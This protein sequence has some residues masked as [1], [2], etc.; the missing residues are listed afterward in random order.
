MTLETLLNE[1]NPH[2]RAAATFA[3]KH[4]LVLAGAGTGK[5]KTIVARAAHLITQ[6]TP[7]HRIHILT[8]TRR[9]AS[10]IV[11][12]VKLHLGE[13]AAGLRA[14]TFHTFCMSLIRQA[15][16]LFGVKGYSVIDRDDQIQLF[17]MIRGGVI[18]KG[19]RFATAAEICNIY[20]YAR[21]TGK[22]LSDTLVEQYPEFLASKEKFAEIMSAYQARKHTRKYLDYDDILDVVVQAM[23]QSEDTAQWIAGH[24]DHLLVDEMQDTNPLQWQILAPLKSLCVLF[25]VGDDAQSIYKFRGADFN[26]IHSFSERVPSSTIFKLTENYR[27][28][29]EILDVSNWLLDQSPLKYNKRLEAVRGS[30]VLPQLHNF[31]NEWEEAGWIT[32]DILQRR[33]EVGDKWNEHM[34]LT[35]SAFGARAMESALLAA[36]IPY[37]YVGGTKLLE[38]AHVRDMLSLVRI[39][40]NPSDELAIIRYLTLFHGVGE[41]TANHAVEAMLAAESLS[42]A[43]VVLKDQKKIPLDAAK[44]IEAVAKSLNNVAGAIREAG[45]TLEKVFETKYQNQDWPKRR[46]DFTMVEK[47]AEKHTSILSFIEEY[48]LDPVHTTQIDHDSTQDVVTL[49]TIHSA[50]GTECKTCYLLN[51]GPGAFPSRLDLGSAD[52]VEES[53]RTLYVALTRAKDNLLVTRRTLNQWAT[54][55]VSDPDIEG[56]FFNTLPDGLFELILHGQKEVDPLGAGVSKVTGYKFVGGINLS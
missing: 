44:G 37:V 9:A 31:R 47:L 7:A 22:S 8:F 1:L 55:E 23:K 40:G 15:P 13:Q 4:A 27:S 16:N 18:K 32:G 14:S 3:S 6:G 34:I 21:N 50:K 35:R 19:E 51:A 46:R 48:M 12:R 39:I 29:Q 53:R 43:I 25:C 41:V 24:F 20:S 54:A 49:I 45:K 5:T 56:Y 36:E 17:R 30:G 10:E 26:N 11:Q 2:Q 52:D 42:D 33:N 38:S 28:T